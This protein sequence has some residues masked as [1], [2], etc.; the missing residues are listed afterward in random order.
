MPSFEITRPG[1]IH[2]AVVCQSTDAARP[3]IN[4]VLVQPGAFKGLP[5]AFIVGTDGHRVSVGY[6]AAATLSEDFPA[7][8]VSIV[9]AKAAMGSLREPLHKDPA[10]A[11]WS[12]DT[13][14]LRVGDKAFQTG[15]QPD[16]TYPDWV[17]VTPSVDD[18]CPP[19]T[20]GGLFEARYLADYAKIARGLGQS[21]TTLSLLGRDPAT[22]HWVDIGEPCW[23]GV[24]MPKRGGNAATMPPWWGG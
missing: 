23:R 19:N 13:E 5:G 2:A 22:P 15:H 8:G 24:L 10:P 14:M 9:V 1:L 17:R 7:D 12:T 16:W 21:T 4:C 20:S 11:T 18:L 6:D 3:Y